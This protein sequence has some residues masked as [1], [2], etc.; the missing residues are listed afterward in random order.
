MLQICCKSCVTLNIL[1]TVKYYDEL[2]R[3]V[4]IDHYVCKLGL[5]NIKNK[6]NN[7]Q[8]LLARC[9]SVMDAI[10]T[11]WECRVDAVGTL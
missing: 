3:K 6:Y 10:K 9:R 2:L 7:F 1:T 5:L 4:A 8:H 11:L